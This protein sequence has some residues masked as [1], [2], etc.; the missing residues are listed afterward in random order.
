MLDING[1]NITKLEINV[2]KHIESRKL[3]FPHWST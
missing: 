3:L 1:R 2:H